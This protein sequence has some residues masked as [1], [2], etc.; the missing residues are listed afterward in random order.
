[1]LMARHVH[2]GSYLRRVIQ[3]NQGFKPYVHCISCEAVMGTK[4]M[5]DRIG[6]ACSRVITPI[7]SGTASVYV[8]IRLE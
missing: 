3:F 7:N 5:T 6:K 1:M 4:A 2:Q 8:H